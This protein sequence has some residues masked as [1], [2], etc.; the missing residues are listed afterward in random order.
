MAVAGQLQRGGRV[1]A[2]PV[3]RPGFTL[4]HAKVVLGQES[5]PPLLTICYDQNTFTDLIIQQNY[6]L[7]R[8]SVY[9]V[10]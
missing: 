8:A 1:A 2:L 5:V 10:T 6:A 9:N 7:K 4:E 3:G